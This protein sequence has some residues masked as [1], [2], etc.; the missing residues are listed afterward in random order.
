[1][2]AS[3]KIIS[4]LRR[5]SAPSLELEFYLVSGLGDTPVPQPTKDNVV[6]FLIRYLN[7][8]RRHFE[9]AIAVRIKTQVHCEAQL[10]TLVDLKSSGPAHESL[11]DIP[12]YIFPPRHDLSLIPY[13]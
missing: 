13:S 1:M 10:M 7:A 3:F 5:T 4:F 9:R 6:S 8:P 2:H 12:V 11:M